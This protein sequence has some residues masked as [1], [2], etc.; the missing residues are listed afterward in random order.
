MWN[1]NAK[2]AT[3][4]H[5][6]TI[7]TLSKP[8]M[9]W[10]KGSFEPIWGFGKKQS[11]LFL[12]IFL[13]FAIETPTWVMRYF[14][15]LGYWCVAVVVI[16]AIFVSFDYTFSQALF[17]GSLYLPSLLCLRIMLPQVD[18]SNRKEGIRNTIFIGA[19]VILL[20][21]LLMLLAN[22]N[23]EAYASCDV[24][25]A[26]INPLFI[27]L[28]LTAIA[29]PQIFIER[30]LGKQAKLQPQTIDFISNR[31]HTSLQMSDIAF[32]ESND[33]EVWIHT[34]SN[35][36]HRTKTTISQ[37]ESILDN[38]NFVRIHRAYLINIIHIVSHNATSITVLDTELPI[39]RKY[40]E[41]IKKK[42]QDSV[43]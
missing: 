35:E 43:N 37:W 18:F 24:H 2:I 41:V 20:T 39:S 14:V 1:S 9:R 11:D 4:L 36:K 22:M 27:T 8:S 23:T 30:W 6:H 12:D 21:I 38:G 13:T 34:T 10:S 3:I 31:H 7:F 17:M 25:G 32:V 40:R 29:T 26:M 28:I 33:S 19:G 15:I 16:A 5:K 42:L